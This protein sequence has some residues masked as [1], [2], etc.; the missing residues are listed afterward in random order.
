MHWRVW[1]VKPK[2]LPA[3]RPFRAICH[4]WLS[5]WPLVK[6]LICLI[7]SSSTYKFSQMKTVS[8]CWPTVIK[9]S[10]EDIT[11]LT[12][13]IPKGCTGPGFG[14]IVQQIPV[15]L[16]YSFNLVYK[17]WQSSRLAGGIN[18]CIFLGE[19]NFCYGLTRTVW[20]HPLHMHFTS[21]H[22]LVPRPSVLQGRD[23]DMRW[24]RVS[25]INN[26]FRILWRG[27]F[28]RKFAPFLAMSKWGWC[29]R[30]VFSYC[31]YGQQW[32]LEY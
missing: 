1:L 26:F 23:P 28:F 11:S 32:L 17:F 6:A 30:H 21:V 4:N 3:S 18:S 22:N 10:S 19:K 12:F 2:L 20:G 9:N 7:R 25:Q 14:L 15:N 27:P 13:G 16:P 31:I 5:L 24:S 8:A 29:T